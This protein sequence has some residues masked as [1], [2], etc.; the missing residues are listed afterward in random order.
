MICLLVLY[1]PSEMIKKNFLGFKKFFTLK[2]PILVDI[3]TLLD[4]YTLH[5]LLFKVE[6]TDHVKDFFTLNT[7]PVGVRIQGS[8]CFVG[9]G[10]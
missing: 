7:H 4:H 6:D 10:G 9:K 5:K 2:L 1:N 8:N 3:K